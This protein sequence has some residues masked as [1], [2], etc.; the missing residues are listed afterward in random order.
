MK[1]N[2]QFHSV[3]RKSF[4]FENL[5]NVFEIIDKYIGLQNNSFMIAGQ[6]E[7]DD[8][9]FKYS[10]LDSE[11]TKNRYKA[12]RIM[13]FSHPSELIEGHLGQHEH[14]SSLDVDIDKSIS[15]EEIEKLFLELSVIL[16]VAFSFALPYHEQKYDISY[17]GH[18]EKIGIKAGLRDVYWLNFFGKPFVDIIS[19][20]KLLNLQVS[21]SLEYGD[22]IYVKLSDSPT[23]AL[24]KKESIKTQI[25]EE[26]F[27]RLS[28]EMEEY[29]ANMPE[30]HG[31]GLL[32]FFKGIIHANKRPADLS[33]A[34]KTPNWNR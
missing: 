34:N 6:E 14:Y 24:A 27:V 12:K 32:V 21:K 8:Y 26:Y 19:S 29:I 4:D 5:L 28:P 33:V 20:E 10:S 22:N 25:G 31:S 23:E 13:C 2:L 17:S 7:K 18:D 16:N 11:Q 30:R 1:I 9:K 15:F 3:N